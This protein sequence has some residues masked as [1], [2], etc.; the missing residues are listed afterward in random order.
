MAA[1]TLFRDRQ[2]NAFQEF[3]MEARTWWAA[4]LFPRLRE[5][6]EERRLVAEREGRAVRT[7]EDVAQLFARSTTYQYFCWLE[8]HVQKSKYSSSR[9]GLI[10]QLA[11]EED[12]ADERLAKAATAR[13]ALDA[14]LPVPEYYAAHDI[15]QHPGNLHGHR[16]AGL[17]YEASALSIHPKTKK[18]ELHE[19]FVELVRRE[20]SF[21]SVLD[22]G[23]GFG[24]STAPL[25]SA[26]PAAKVVG[27][28]L[29]AP[30]L[31]LAAAE[32]AGLANLSFRQ[33]DARHTGLAPASFDL[34]TSTMLLHELPAQAVDETLA[35][36]HRL[37]APGGVSVH[38]DFRT[39]DPFW[40]F[41]MYG[42]GVRNNEP[43][44][45]PLIRMDL[46]ASYRKAGFEA[47][48]IE[49]FAERKGATDPSNPFWR[50]PWAAIIARKPAA[51][52]AT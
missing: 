1:L 14:R 52:V 12:R 9:W 40:Q 51:G 47:V 41:I 28:D 29:S 8:R 42:H 20:G 3:I 34:V 46:A 43:F 45:E 18:N 39:D 2:A 24:K 38:L 11:R 13:P 19:R 50:F 26:F 48:R 31:D 30:C 37:L 15:H 10:A 17:V 7:A 36:T 23:C 22:M 25:A 21:T 49:P 6:Y 4:E 5:E 16:H 33:A 44:L 32:A 27:V 35:E